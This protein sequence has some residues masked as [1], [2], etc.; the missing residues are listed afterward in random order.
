MIFATPSGVRPGEAKRGW[1][2]EFAGRLT[3]DRISRLGV[4]VQSKAAQ[5]QAWPSRAEHGTRAH[6]AVTDAPDFTATRFRARLGI[7]GQGAA[8]R[9]PRDTGAVIF[10]RC[11][12]QGKARRGKAE[13]GPASENTGRK[14]V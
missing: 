9:V 12:T 13:L 8:S 3:G 6:R 10:R 5:R 14:Q 11:A 1:A 7:S 4:A 2:D